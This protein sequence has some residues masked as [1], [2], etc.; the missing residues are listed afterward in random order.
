MKPDK[1]YRMS[2]Q[3]KIIAAMIKDP[4]ERGK[5]KRMMAE[6]EYHAS[7]I[8]HK[9]SIKAIMGDDDGPQTETQKD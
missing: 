7:T 8:R 3:T 6:A 1:N 9:M 2:S 4:H 5:Y